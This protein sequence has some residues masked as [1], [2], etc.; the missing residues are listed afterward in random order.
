MKTDNFEAQIAGKQSHLLELA[1][2]CFQVIVF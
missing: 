2:G 1:R